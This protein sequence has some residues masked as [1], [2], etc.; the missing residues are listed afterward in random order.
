MRVK[1]CDEDGAE[2]A[3]AEPA[4]AEPAGALAAETLGAAEPAADEGEPL[5]APDEAAAVAVANSVLVRV[6]VCWTVVELGD[7]A[8]APVPAAALAVPLL[9]MGKGAAAGD[10]AAGA[11][12]AAGAGELGAA[13]AGAG[14]LA[15]GD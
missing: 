9:G 10:L 5:A 11:L 1:V 13:A 4:G 14:A 12:G 15:A 8:G 7:L 2:A 6:M 3:G